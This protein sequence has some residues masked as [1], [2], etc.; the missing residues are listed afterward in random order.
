MADV[1]DGTSNTLFF[2]ERSH[3][4]PVFDS[5]AN[6]NGGQQV[7]GQYGLWHSAGGLAVVDA[8][9]TTLAP[10][11]YGVDASQTWNTSACLRTSGFG[12][13][14]P[15][16]ANLALVDG[17]VRFFSQT[18]DMPLYRALSTR[19]GGEVASAP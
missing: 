18:I 19:A 16:G 12:S 2:G 6:A 17:S 10:I 15:G 7:I 13:L 9:M 8:T 4:D 1:L 5:Q 11:N 3:V 14:H